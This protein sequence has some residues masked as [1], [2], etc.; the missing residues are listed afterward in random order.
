VST[1]NTRSGGAEKRRCPSTT[2]TV[3][4]TSA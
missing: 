1:A 3:A 4:E 2:V